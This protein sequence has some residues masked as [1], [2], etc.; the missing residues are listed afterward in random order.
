MSQ[1]FKPGDKVKCIADIVDNFYYGK[2]GTA[3]KYDL[4]GNFYVV[5]DD[6]SVKMTGWSCDYYFEPMLACKNLISKDLFIEELFE[7]E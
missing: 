1:R 7:N 3:V 6:G 2:T 5:W 4:A